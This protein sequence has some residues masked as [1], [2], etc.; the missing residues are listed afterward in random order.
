[1]AEEASTNAPCHASRH[2]LCS[3]REVYILPQG[4]YVRVH[5]IMQSHAF[6]GGKAH[7][8]D[9]DISVGNVAWLCMSQLIRRRHSNRPSGLVTF[10]GETTIAIGFKRLAYNA[11]CYTI[12]EQKSVA[13][14]VDS[15]GH[16]P[17][18]KLQL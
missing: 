8:C 12:L 14:I 15:D 4:S 11:L 10:G 7:E 2:C 9:G 5:Q 1:M 17:I 16:V 18:A 13:A 3:R 6:S